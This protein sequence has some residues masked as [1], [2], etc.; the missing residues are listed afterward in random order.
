MGRGSRVITALLAALLAAAPVAAT[1]VDW[2]PAPVS[3]LPA[4]DAALAPVHLSLRETVEGLA[5]VSAR[6]GTDLDALSVDAAAVT[7]VW[8]EFQDVAREGLATLDA[9]PPEPCFADYWAIERVGFLRLGDSAATFPRGGGA[10]T[11]ALALIHSDGLGLPA[12]ADLVRSVTDCGGSP[13]A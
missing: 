13:D 7:A 2:R 11:E 3:R 6:V 4:L 12:Y 9:F 1:H 8:H 5:A 10:Y